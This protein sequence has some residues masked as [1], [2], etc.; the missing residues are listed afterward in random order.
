MMRSVCDNERKNKRKNINKV[1][2]FFF[3]GKHHKC[4]S[5]KC[6]Q[7]TRQAPLYLF[8]Q[9]QLCRRESLKDWLK[10]NTQ[11]DHLFCLQ[12]FEQVGH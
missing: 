2:L 11:R 1:A 7:D 3:T 9:M 4:K 12:I 5:E 10:S 6:T 8:I